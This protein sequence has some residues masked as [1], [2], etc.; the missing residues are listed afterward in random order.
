MNDIEKMFKLT[1]R[2]SETQNV[3][4]ENQKCGNLKFKNAKI[5][6]LKKSKV[7]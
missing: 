3:K 5:K 7:F 6:K 2:I 4:I 1:M